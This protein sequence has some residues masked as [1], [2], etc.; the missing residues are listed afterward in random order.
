MEERDTATSRLVLLL[1][2]GGELVV[3]GG[4]DGTLEVGAASAHLAVGLDRVAGAGLRVHLVDLLKREETGLVDEE[5]GEDGTTRAGTGPDE[6]DL[7]AKTSLAGTRVDKV[8][9]GVT[10]TE[11][12]EPVGGSAERESLG[13]DG[14][15][16]DLT[17]NDPGGGTPGGGET[18][19][20]DADKCDERLATSGVGLGDSST[21]DSDDELASAHPDGTEDEEVSSTD[22]L[23]HV[24]AWNGGD[25]VDNVGDNGEDEGV[26]I[27]KSAL[28]EL[29]AV[30]KDEVDTGELLEG[31]D[32]DTSERA[33]EVSSVVELEAVEVR[34]GGVSELNVEVGLDDRE[35]GADNG[36]VDISGVEAGEGLGSLL[37]VALLDEPTRGFGEDEEETAEDKGESELDTDG[38]TPRAGV[39]A[40]LGAVGS[41]RSAEK[42]DGDGPLVTGNNGTTD[43]TGGSLGLVHGNNSGKDTNTETSNDTTTDEDTKVSGSHL[44]D[45]TNAEDSKG[46]LHTPSTTEDIGDGSTGKG[47]AESTG[48]KDRDDERGVVCGQ[49]VLAVS[50]KHT[51]GLL[52]V[53]HDKE[54]G[55]CTSVV[56]E[57]NTTESGGG[58]NEN[59]GERLPNAGGAGHRASGGNA[60]VGNSTSGHLEED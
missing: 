13:T 1:V 29:G 58:G 4:S 53:V 44:H 60:D 17:A 50:H 9:G 56:T 6:E 10:D 54:T 37:M 23:H 14:K 16:E 41:E 49:V 28:E 57:E 52:E 7:G 36:V 40:A 59:S 42:T 34:A 43:P 55:D 11:V 31:L 20:V 22:T 39:L 25:N 46:D 8:R 24:H 47:T 27:R 33:E 51:E 32:E 21:D 35:L 15:G 30:V 5:V 48:R 18:G 3:L 2:V 12:P 19:N 26:R 38:D 45:D